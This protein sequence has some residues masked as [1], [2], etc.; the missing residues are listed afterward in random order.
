MTHQEVE[1]YRADLTTS[2]LLRFDI[3]YKAADIFILSERDVS[4]EAERLLRSA[5]G[6]VEDYIRFDPA[7]GFTLRPHRVFAGVAS[8]VVL[9][10]SSAAA[11]FGV[12]PMAAVAGAIAEFIG[13][14]LDADCIVVEN[15]GDVFARAR[16]VSVRIDCGDNPRFRNGIRI[17][18][19]ADGG[20]GI[21][22]SSRNGRSLSF[23]MADAFCVVADSA[24]DA[25]AAATA[26]GNRIKRPDD[27]RR[28]VEEALEH[29]KVRAA[30]SVAGDV[31][32]LGG[33]IRLLSL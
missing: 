21:C 13:K 8:E 12:G 6:S 22:T 25:D 1:R 31:L 3:T 23:G 7:F 18:V 26:F 2:G 10:M 16:E 24:A 5:Y 20:V 28:V 27:V 19:E 17:G 9:N 32:A 15:G 4:E 33:E 30:V 14:N 29:P 11:L